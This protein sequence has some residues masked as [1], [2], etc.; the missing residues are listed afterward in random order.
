MA[1]NDILAELRAK[2]GD[3]PEENEKI[4][5]AEGEKFAADGNYDGL[6]AVGE[7]IIENMPEERRNEL[8]RLTHIDG[9]RL[10]EVYADI[11]ALV[12][13]K[14]Y[15]EALPIAEKLYKKVCLEYAETDKAKFVSLRNPSKRL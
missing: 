11:E 7:I 6:K 2:L 4:L 5:K 12:K 8:D 3:S 9:K 10:D 13:E 1:Y 15:L 14:K